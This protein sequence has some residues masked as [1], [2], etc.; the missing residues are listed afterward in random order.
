MTKQHLDYHPDADRDDETT[1]VITFLS[2]IHER[3][4]ALL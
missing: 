2:L 1:L 4:R 3:V